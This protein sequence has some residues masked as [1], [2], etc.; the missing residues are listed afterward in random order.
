MPR[1]ANKASRRSRR[2]AP[3]LRLVGA[4]GG[5]QEDGEL[6]QPL[7]AERGEHPAGDGPSELYPTA[8][9]SCRI[10]RTVALDSVRLGTCEA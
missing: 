8:H 5:F 10:V 6:V 2:I 4:L 9:P 1:E 3:A 7:R